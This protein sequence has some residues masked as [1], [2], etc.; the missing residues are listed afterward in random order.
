MQWDE[1]KPMA[2]ARVAQINK[3]EVKN[4]TPMDRDNSMTYIS[5]FSEGYDEAVRQMGGSK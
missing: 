1:I 3:G 2:Q 4:W 5:A